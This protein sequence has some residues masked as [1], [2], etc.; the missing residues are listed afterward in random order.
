MFSE[1]FER[2]IFNKETNFAKMHNVIHG[3]LRIKSTD[4]H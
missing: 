4:K 1:Q 3:T 2:I